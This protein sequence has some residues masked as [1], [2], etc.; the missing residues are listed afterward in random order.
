[1]NGSL[2]PISRFARATRCAQATA[3]RLPV[4][5]EPV[6]ATQSTRSSCVIA[7][8]TSPAPAIRFTT[9][10]GRWSKQPAQHQRRKRRQLR[11]L[12][13]GRVAGGQ[14]GRELPGQQQQRVVPGHDA[15]HHAH[16]LLQHQGEL[17]RLDRRDHAAGAVAPDLRVV[18]ERGR[19]PA[20]LVGVLEQR[21]AALERHHPGQLVGAGAQPRRH[22]VQHLAAL[23]RGRARPS[24]RR[25]ARGRDR[26]V[27][28]LGAGSATPAMRL[29]GVRVLDVQRRPV[30]G[31]LLAAD[32][33]PRLEHQTRSIRSVI[34]TSPV[35]TR[36][37]GH[38]RCDHAQPLDLLV[39]ERLREASAARRSATVPSGSSS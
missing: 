33:E 14:R 34:S 38:L 1:M 21:L 27:H 7:S 36:C 20:D 10:A 17:G 28:L 2:P 5:T 39:R 4:S 13:D 8:P 15:A 23:D 9:P 19:G 12:A 3:T 32:Q 30:A 35:S 18:V 24:A 6:N 22:L 16:R 11:R 25:F 31:D 26:G 37:T 29:L